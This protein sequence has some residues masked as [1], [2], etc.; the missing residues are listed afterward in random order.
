MTSEFHCAPGQP[1]GPVLDQI[2]A[3]VAHGLTDDV[4][5]LF[6][7]GDYFWSA[8]LVLDASLSGTPE[9]RVVFAAEKGAH[10]V[11]HGGERVTGWVAVEP[12]VY[13]TLEAM[14]FRFRTL[15]VDGRRATCARWPK[16]VEGAV[17]RGEYLLGKKT[18]DD[19]RHALGFEPGD[20]PEVADASV[21]RLSV[22]PAEDDGRN[23]HHNLVQ[24]TRLDTERHELHWELATTWGAGKGSRYFLEGAMEFLT[25]DGEWAQDSEGYLFYRGG[26]AWDP[27]NSLVVAPQTTCLL[28]FCGQPGKPVHHLTVEGLTL[29]DT[30]LPA[31][32]CHFV[33]QVPG[34]VCLE[35]AEHNTVR[36]CEI[37]NTGWHGFHLRGAVRGN[38]LTLNDVRHIGHTGV[39]LEDFP[40]GGG[41]PYRHRETLVDGNRI[42]NCGEIVGHA[43]CI[44]LIDSGDNRITRNFLRG[45]PRYALGMSSMSRDVLGVENYS[46]YQH[47]RNNMIAYNDMSCANL[48][49]QD[50]GVLQTW[51]PGTGNVFHANFIHDSTI[52]FSFGTGIYLDDNANDLKVTGNLVCHLQKSGGGELGTA[53]VAKGIGDLIENNVF[54]D[55]RVAASGGAIGSTDMARRRENYD[56]SVRRNLMSSTGRLMHVFSTWDDDRYRECN[57]NLYWGPGEVGV[58]GVRHVPESIDLGSWQQLEGGRFDAQSLVADPKF[59]DSNTADYRLA[60][61]SPAYRVGFRELELDA[62]GLPPEFSG[63]LSSGQPL[64]L[65]T[66]RIADPEKPNRGF[67]RLSPGRSLAVAT[68]GRTSGGMRLSGPEIGSLLWTSSS[69]QVASIDNSGTVTAHGRGITVVTATLADKPALA[70]RLFVVVGE[71][72]EEAVVS[73]PRTQF[74]VGEEFE[75]FAVARGDL[76]GY[77]PDEF[78]DCQASPTGRLESLSNGRWRAISP[79]AVVLSFRAEVNGNLLSTDVPVS[80][81]VERDLELKLEA[82][83]RL[84]FTGKP[85]Q[86]SATVL[87]SDSTLRPVAASELDFELPD[88]LRLEGSRLEAVAAGTGVLAARL[89]GSPLRANLKLSAIVETPVPPGW[90]VHNLGEAAGLA[91]FDQGRVI[92]T[93][94]GENIW[95]QADDTTFASRQA[96]PGWTQLECRLVSVEET[97]PNAQA[98]LL[99][100]AGEGDGA[101]CLNLRANARGGVML[102]FRAEAGHRVEGLFDAHASLPLLLRV[103]SH[104]GHWRFLCR[105]DSL[106]VGKSKE[107][108]LLGEL[109]WSPTQTLLAGLTA[110]SNN[111]STPT[112][113]VFDQLS[114]G[115]KE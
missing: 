36:A 81:I 26:A 107:W 111:R 97:S 60:P 46:D 58:F 94:N 16:K 54:A 62:M 67:V 53:I 8:P 17:P 48:D 85:A 51:N 29:C 103:E 71:L 89:R 24:V 112:T 101:A 10:P 14:P 76:G 56:Q 102:A 28:H 45:A 114:G 13:R 50:T 5:V 75:P 34:T 11:F 40:R 96:L 78:F 38:E 69:P 86:L 18:C 82:S 64:E 88:F 63:K 115:L 33:T 1:L 105:E 31:Q 73:L 27:R 30:D 4:R 104:S 72:P 47:C 109:D 93:S 59:L 91:V 70:S 92:V 25:Q 55:N 84:L 7:G 65:A 20:F 113:A 19:R 80:V 22:W 41:G 98:G 43:S 23:W 9:H 108:V 83:S 87:T 2:R 68:S 79:G 110:F 42:T 6:A 74:A 3:R 49:S 21:L 95:F 12:G 90:G 39:Q 52:S 100:R 32:Y 106:A 57:L 77:Y 15:Y 35:Q 37:V 66:L 44:E 61:D 99:L